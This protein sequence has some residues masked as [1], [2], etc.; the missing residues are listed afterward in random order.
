M[1]EWTASQQF[2]DQEFE[3]E[4]EDSGVEGRL[5]CRGYVYLNGPILK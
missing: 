5:Q 2:E 4:N 1:C 3:H